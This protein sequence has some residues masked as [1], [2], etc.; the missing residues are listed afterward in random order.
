MTDWHIPWPYEETAAM[1]LALRV[2]LSPTQMQLVTKAANV[3]YEQRDEFLRAVARRL[4][5]SP[6]DE[7]VIAALKE[8]TDDQT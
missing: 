3:P 4:G 8:Q 7:K 5:T 2:L 1:P 6:S